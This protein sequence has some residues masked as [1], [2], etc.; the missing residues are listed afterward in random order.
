VAD[1]GEL[2]GWTDRPSEALPGFDVFCLPSRS[3]GFPL[4]IVEATLAGLP[5]VACRVGSVAEL[6]V[7][8]DT[9][10]VVERD[11]VDG[12][13]SALTQLRT[14]RCGTGSARPGGS[15]RGSTT[16]S[17]TWRGPTSSCGNASQP[18]HKPHASARPR[19]VRDPALLPGDDHA[20]VISGVPCVAIP[21][22]NVTVRT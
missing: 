8:G 15:G 11:D 3:E 9:G 4:S 7:D 22:R 13:V 16:P 14:T 18:R 12:L 10:F 2:P 5:V 19:R 17:S 1:R 20:P 21:D 6:V